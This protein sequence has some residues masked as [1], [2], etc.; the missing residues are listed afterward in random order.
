MAKKVELEIAI[1]ENSKKL[2]D[3]INRLEKLENT[4]KKI[5][6]ST[7]IS[8]GLFDV[9]KISSLI[10]SFDRLNLTVENLTKKSSEFIENLNLTEVAFYGNTE[11]VKKLY[12]EMSNVYNL[13]ESQ[14][15][16]RLGIFKQMANAMQ[17]PIEAGEELSELMNKMTI[18]IASLYNIDIDR[19]SNALQSALVGQTRPINSSGLTLK[20]VMNKIVN[21]SK[22]GVRVIT[23]L[24]KQEMAY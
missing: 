1:T 21:T 19:A 24:F 10:F 12:T 8:G 16:R 23:M 6:K 7:N 15:V 11:Q 22:S 18:D 9:A 3:I 13:D 14:I 20:S 4:S 5:K 17:L 2:D